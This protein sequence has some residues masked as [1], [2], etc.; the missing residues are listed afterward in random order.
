MI[1][2]WL[3]LRLVGGVEGLNTI[4]VRELMKMGG[5]MGG[6]LKRL[7][8]RVRRIVKNLLTFHIK[9]IKQS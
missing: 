6:G 7:Y 4:Y 1:V 3:G 2:S 8:H 9:L 5:R